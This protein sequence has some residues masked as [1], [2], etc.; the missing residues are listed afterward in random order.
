MTRFSISSL[1]VV[2]LFMALILADW[3][4]HVIYAGLR[5]VGL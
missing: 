4:V 1:I 5:S 3:L 2:A